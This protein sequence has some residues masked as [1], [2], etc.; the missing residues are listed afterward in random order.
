MALFVS[1][2]PGGSI[3]VLWH[4]TGTNGDAACAH[5]TNS[6]ING[7]AGDTGDASPTTAHITFSTDLYCKCR[8]KDPHYKESF[9]ETSAR[10]L[11][12]KRLP[13]SLYFL[14]HL[15]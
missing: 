9:G 6:M 7:K 10:K 14:K 5:S 8:Q 12:R 13:F 11:V 2:E 3:G 15:F 1:L 4:A